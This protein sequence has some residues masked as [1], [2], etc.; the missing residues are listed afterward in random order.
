MKGG[1]ARQMGSLLTTK[2]SEEYETLGISGKKKGEKEGE[3]ERAGHIEG[4]H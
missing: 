2:Q 4:E 1:R 3:A